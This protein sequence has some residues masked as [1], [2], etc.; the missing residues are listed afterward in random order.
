[1]KSRAWWLLQSVF[2][3]WLIGWRVLSLLVRFNQYEGSTI[4]IP[5]C[6]TEGEL[7]VRLSIWVIWLTTVWVIGVSIRVQFWQHVRTLWFVNAVAVILS[8]RSIVRYRA[9]IQY[10]EQL[11]HY[12]K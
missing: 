7:G 2:L 3:L 5:D 9:L 4:P 12:C 6:N 1:M 8:L 10:S 11:Q